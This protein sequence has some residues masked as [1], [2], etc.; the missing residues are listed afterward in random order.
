MLI[1]IDPGS[2]V[3]MRSGLNLRIALLWSVQPIPG[4]HEKGIEINLRQPYPEPALVPLGE[5]PKVRKSN[6]AK[7]TRQ[8]SPVTSA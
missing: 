7:G 2:I 8:I 4:V 5:K 1:R 3:M 6:L